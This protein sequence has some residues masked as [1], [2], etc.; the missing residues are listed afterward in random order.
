MIHNIVFDMS[1]TLIPFET[2]FMMQNAGVP[3]E[4]YE[5]FRMEV[6]HSQ[7]W[8]AMDRGTMEEEEAIRRICENLPEHLHNCVGYFIEHVYEGTNPF[9]EMYDLVNECQNAG[10]QTYLLSNASTRF[11]EKQHMIP[12]I[13]LMDGV[14]VSCEVKLLKPDP[15]IYNLFFERFGIKPETCFFIDDVPSNV[16]A[17]EYCGMRGFVFRRNVE[18]LRSSMRKA[19]IRV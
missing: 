16:E 9:L 3:E 15:A 2:K 14:F 17:A 4:D 18:R 19:G 5:L 6:V 8:Q 1:N 10:Y 13:S 7:E 11:Y 12:A